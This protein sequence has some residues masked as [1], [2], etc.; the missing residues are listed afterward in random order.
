[1]NLRIRW[2]NKEND[3][4]SSLSFKSIICAAQT[5]KCSWNS[6]D[7]IFK[8]KQYFEP[9]SALTDPDVSVVTIKQ[10]KIEKIIWSSLTHILRFRMVHRF[11]ALCKGNGDLLGYQKSTHNNFHSNGLQTNASCLKSAY[12]FPRKI[13]RACKLHYYQQSYLV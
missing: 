12:P 6:K 1:M 2:A 5:M 7:Q 9:D 10:K 13:R 8:T 4:L 3:S 11:K